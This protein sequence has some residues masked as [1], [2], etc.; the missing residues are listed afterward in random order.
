[1]SRIAS[2]VRRVSASGSTRRN[3]PAGLSNVE[4]PSAVT[5]RYGVSRGTQREEV[6]VGELTHEAHGTPRPGV[7]R[8]DV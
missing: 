1:M 4:T 6:G 2:D 5:S 7:R 8:N 3:S